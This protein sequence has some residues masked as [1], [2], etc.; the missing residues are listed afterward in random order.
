ML[1][2]CMSSVSNPSES[3]EEEAGSETFKVLAK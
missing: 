1:K 2:Y 3:F